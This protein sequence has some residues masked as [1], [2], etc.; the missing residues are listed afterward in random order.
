MFY[1]LYRNILRSETTRRKYYVIYILRRFILSIILVC[2]SSPYLQLTLAILLQMSCTMF[3]C[4]QKQFLR[5][6]DT[7]CAIMTESI[8]LVILISAYSFPKDISDPQGFDFKNHELKGLICNTIVC[9]T[10]IMTIPINIVGKTYE[11]EKKTQITI[12]TL[13]VSSKAFAIKEEQKQEDQKQKSKTPANFSAEDRKEGSLTKEPKPSMIGILSNPKVLPS[14][15]K[16]TGFEGK[17]K[18]KEY[19]DKIIVTRLNRNPSKIKPFRS[20]SDIDKKV[21]LSSQ[22]SSNLKGLDSQDS[23]DYNMF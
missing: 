5:L 8:I 19:G 2:I 10:I 22:L 16:K 9:V 12:N 13:K 7:I 3:L 23:V 18:L 6:T 20:I 4:L 14:A 1:P 17:A 21:E 11:K 15:L